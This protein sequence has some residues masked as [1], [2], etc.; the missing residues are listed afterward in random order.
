MLTAASSRPAI[1]AALA[2]VGLT[3]LTACSSSFDYAT[4]R[5][6]VIANGGYNTAVTSDPL[7]VSAAVIVATAP[8]GDKGAATKGAFIATIALPPQQDPATVTT[9]TVKKLG[10]VGIA[11][12]TAAKGANGGALE[13]TDKVTGKPAKPVVVGKTGSNNLALTGGIPVTGSFTPGDQIP[14]VITLAGGASI[15]ITVPVV[16]KCGYYASSAPTPA[17]QANPGTYSCA[18]PAI[19]DETAVGVTPAASAAAKAP[20]KKASAKAAHASATAKPTK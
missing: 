13:T 1:A 10:I 14:L 5:P 12:D 7:R 8:A 18:R 9:A 11:V 17:D 20:A 6:N 15:H 19:P 2:A 3:A 16:S 4:D